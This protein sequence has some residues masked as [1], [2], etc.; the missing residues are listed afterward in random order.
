MTSTIAG[1]VPAERPETTIM[2]VWPSIASYAAGRWWGRLFAIQF[3]GLYILRLGNLLALLSIP[4]VLVLYFYR[5]LPRVGTR[6]RLTNR[7]IVVHCGLTLTERTSI[8]LEAFDAI[9]IDVRPGQDWFHAGDLVFRRGGAEVFR[10]EG[11]SRPAA[12]RRTC[13]DARTAR[14]TVQQVL[15]RQAS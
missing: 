3:P 13:L 5:V 7:R 9:D 15:A 11:V 4:H 10:L 14:V 6:Y 2:T 12:F 1:S 8:D